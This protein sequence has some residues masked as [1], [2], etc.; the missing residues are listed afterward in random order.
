[1]ATAPF[2][3]SLCDVTMAKLIWT[4]KLQSSRTPTPLLS[5]ATHVFCVSIS[6]LLPWF[7]AD[8]YGSFTVLLAFSGQPKPHIGQNNKSDLSLTPQYKTMFDLLYICIPQRCLQY[9]E[10]KSNRTY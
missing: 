2:S 10:I 4:N 6:L 9:R 7:N 5:F 8:A 3:D 1:M